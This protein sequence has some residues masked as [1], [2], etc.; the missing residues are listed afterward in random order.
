MSDTQGVKIT[1]E[2]GVLEFCAIVTPD[3]LDLDAIAGHD[4]VCEASQ[5]IPHFSLIENYVHPGVSRVVINN[6]KAIEMCS[7]SEGRVVSRAK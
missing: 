2:A 4:R 7:R 6:N 5:D 3:V 1:V